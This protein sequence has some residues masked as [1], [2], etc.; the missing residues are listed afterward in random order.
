[1]EP[2]AAKSRP[3]KKMIFENVCIQR[4]RPKITR[5]EIYHQAT[6]LEELV[7]G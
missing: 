7:R 5:S 3:A 2:E 1:M 4:F 6:A